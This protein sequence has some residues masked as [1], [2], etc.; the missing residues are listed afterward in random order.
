MDAGMDTNRGVAGSS[1]ELCRVGGH[2]STPASTL[3]LLTVLATISSLRTSNV[4]SRVGKLQHSIL[5]DTT[6]NI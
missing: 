5:Q 1:G 3:H 2:P 6:I 4:E